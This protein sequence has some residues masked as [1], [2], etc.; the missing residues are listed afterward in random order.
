MGILPMAEGPPSSV[1]GIGWV[2][3][4]RLG[5]DETHRL[6]EGRRVRDPRCRGMV[7]APNSWRMITSARNVEILHFVHN[8]TNRALPPVILRE[9]ASGGRLKNLRDSSL[10]SE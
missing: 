6:E 9:S 7:S 5:R 3:S 1:G 4:A 10:R 2:Q 8:D